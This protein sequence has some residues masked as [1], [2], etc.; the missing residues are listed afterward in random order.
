MEES[1]KKDLKK[2]FENTPE[3]LEKLQILSIYW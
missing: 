2:H 3:H 1:K